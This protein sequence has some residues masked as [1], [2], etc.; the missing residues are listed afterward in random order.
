[1]C[2]KIQ[3]ETLYRLATLQVPAKK[4]GGGET[5]YVRNKANS[6]YYVL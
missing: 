5:K 1:M 3:R 4:K 2:K 6:A